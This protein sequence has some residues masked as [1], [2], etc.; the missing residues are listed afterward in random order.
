ML[1]FTVNKDVYNNNISTASLM[2]SVDYIAKI[3]RRRQDFK[4]KSKFIKSRRTKVASNTA[5]QCEEGH[6]TKINNIG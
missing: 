6:K 2:R 4:S 5:R 1:P 3:Q